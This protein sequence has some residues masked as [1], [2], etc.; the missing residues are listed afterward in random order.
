MLSYLKISNLAILED[1]SLE[2]GPGFNVLTG[3]TGAGKSIVVDALGLV[4]GEKGSGEMVRS[5]CDQLVVEAQFDLT[6]RPD[7]SIFAALAGLDTE[8]WDGDLIIRRDLAPNGRGRVHVNGRLTSLAAL[9]SLGERL[10]DI[11]GQHGHQSLLR[12]EGQRD[13]L[14]G[15]AGTGPLKA[16]VASAHAV[17]RDLER[18]LEELKAMEMDRARSVEML[19]HTVEEIEAV[20]PAPGEDEDLRREESLLRN[21]EE[22][23]RLSSECLGLVSEDDDSVVVKLGVARDRLA[24]LAELDPAAGEA[25]SLAAEAHVAATE[26]GRVLARAA[27][28][29]EADPGRL[30]RVASRLAAID[31]LTRRHGGTIG[32]ILEELE[33]ARAGLEELGTVS[34][35]LA[36]LPERLAGAR[37]AYGALAGKLTARRLKAS[38]GLAA[39]LGTEVRPLGMESARFLIRVDPREAP[40]PDGMDRIEFLLS[41]NAGEELRP[42]ER[43]ASGGELSRVMLAVRNAGSDASDGRSLIFDEVDS[44]IGGR[45]AGMVGRRLAQLARRQQVLCVTHLPQIAVLA[46]R[47]FCVGKR[48]RGPRTVAE[49]TQLDDRGRIDEIARMLGGSPADVARRHAEAMM[50]RSRGAA[51]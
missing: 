5:G 15:Y 18:E 8:S 32:A 12:E 13:A 20:A 38:E 19:R 44:G 2:P 37:S 47:H 1:V 49:V 4:L 39:E 27:D 21:A 42:L 51:S 10:A 9:R 6:D 26:L 33:R 46:D 34:D 48:A 29:E 7:A 36:G 35:R 41:A 14:D 30:D 3:E 24:R 45:V 16:E 11:H 50:T 31:R 40:G 25:V 28:V 23:A 22:I 17:L 43:I